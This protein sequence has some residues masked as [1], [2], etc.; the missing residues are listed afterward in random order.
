MSP[1]VLTMLETIAQWPSSQQADF[2]Q[3]AWDQLVDSGWLPE[4]DDELKAEL[5]RRGSELDEKPDSAISFAD[6]VAYWRRPR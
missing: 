1:D 5:D 2:F 6:A 4:V 3:L